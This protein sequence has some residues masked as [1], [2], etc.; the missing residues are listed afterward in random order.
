MANLKPTQAAPDAISLGQ[1]L[2]QY[3][4]KTDAQ[5]SGK[6]YRS[7]TKYIT[8]WWGNALV[9]DLTMARQREFIAHLGGKGFSPGYIKRIVGIISGAVGHAV[10]NDVLQVRV[11]VMMSLEKIAARVDRASRTPCRRLTIPEIAAFIDAI[12]APHML[13]Y[14][15]LAINTL[16]RPAS[17]LELRW[18]QIGDGLIRLN[19]PGRRQTKKYRPT[20]PVTDTLNAWLRGW[21]DQIPHLIHFHGRKIDDPRVG[22]QNIAMRAGLMTEADVATERSIHPYTF[23]RSMARILR[24]RGVSMEDL[25]AWMGHR[26]P[27]AATTEVFYA[28]AAPDYM[29]STKHAIDDVMVEIGSHMKSTPIRPAPIDESAYHFGAKRLYGAV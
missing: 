11:P 8:A 21:P 24:G 1:I 9:S 6:G 29:A 12:E 25:G 28:D 18:S 17:I 26:V 15:L 23:R 7:A 16:A 20:I 10:E 19:P 13:R 14:T 3:L 27:G 5:P 22:M 2:L 4:T